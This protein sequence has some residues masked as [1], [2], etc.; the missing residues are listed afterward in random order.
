MTESTSPST[1]NPADPTSR[2]DICAAPGCSISRSEVLSFLAGREREAAI[3]HARL[4]ALAVVA[5]GASATLAVYI[6]AHP[7]LVEPQAHA[8]RLLFASAAFGCVAYASF[9]HPAVR[10]LT[11]GVVPPAVSEDVRAA[12]RPLLRFAI[13]NPVFW[14]FAGLATCLI[15]IDQD[16]SSLDVLGVILVGLF[17]LVTLVL[18]SGINSRVAE[19]YSKLQP[20]QQMMLL[21]PMLLLALILLLYFL[22]GS[23]SYQDILTSVAFVVLPVVAL[24]TLEVLR[25]VISDA[26]PQ[27]VRELH[28]EALS[29]GSD[30]RLILQSYDVIE[31][32]R[33]IFPPA[34]LPPDTD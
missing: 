8:A 12:G 18:E 6:A 7:P 21:F 17:A 23:L 29:A 25:W 4:W 11:Q 14:A 34:K 19:F 24:A 15:G 32:Q 2:T 10:T 1:G 16:L 20:L 33:R 31:R 27:L 28:R 30:V 22:G 13:L 5:F 26:T 3:A 9:V